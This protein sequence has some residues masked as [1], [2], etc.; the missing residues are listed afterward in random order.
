MEREQVLATLAQTYDDAY[1]EYQTLMALGTQLLKDGK[2]ETYHI[3]L[4]EARFLPCFSRDFTGQCPGS[5]GISW[6]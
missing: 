1:R 6:T 5:S 4:W 2:R 3:K